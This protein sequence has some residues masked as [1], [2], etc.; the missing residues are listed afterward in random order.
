[1]TYSRHK[2]AEAVARKSGTELN[3]S[4]RY[5]GVISGTSQRG[6]SLKKVSETFRKGGSVKEEECPWG[7][8]WLSNP[9]NYWNLI[10]DLSQVRKDAR[11]YRGG[12]YS[13]V[14]SKSAIRNAL[15]FSPVQIGVGVGSNWENSVVYKPSSILAYHA[16]TLYNMDDKYLYIQDSLG[17]E[18]KKL[19]INYPIAVAQSFRDLPDNWKE[20]NNNME[21]IE[22]K[23]VNGKKKVWGIKNGKKYWFVSWQDVADW[24]GYNSLEKAQE[25]V[26]G[27]EAGHLDT[28]PFGGIVGSPS[29]WDLIFGKG[30]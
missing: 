22:L 1:M 25:A 19:D 26:Q 29:I 12:S 28:Y 18:F 30:R 27:V 13:L 15:A 23:R 17:R 5:L 10:N 4:D 3:L 21:Q 16:I 2:C 6:N 7:S 20:L 8:G 14:Y 11:R 9:W 24:A